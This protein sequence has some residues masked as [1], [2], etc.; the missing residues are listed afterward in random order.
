MFSAGNLSTC[1]QHVRSIQRRLDKAVADND[2]G[3]IRETFD[4][5]THRSQAVRVLA[6]W[7]ATQQH[8]IRHIAGIDNIAIPKDEPRDSQN[9]R[10]EK[11]VAAID[12]RKRPDP[13]RRVLIPEKRRIGVP[14][15]HDRIVQE[16]FRI[17]LEPIVEYHFNPRN[18]GC[19][20][21]R[22]A[23]DAV[24]QLLLD[25]RS[26][27]S[28]H[29][30]IRGG[31]RGCFGRIRV[32]PIR[33]TLEAWGTPAWAAET[34]Q[35][36]LETG[37]FRNGA[38][39]GNGT[40]GGLPPLLANVALTVLDA[41]CEHRGNGTH[42]STPIVR[43]VDDFVILCRSEPEAERVKDAVAEHLRDTL[44]L[45]R[46]E[47]KTR[48]VP[49]SKGFNFLG[50]TFREDARVYP[51]RA[52]VRSLLRA[53]KAVLETQKSAT[54]RHVIKRLTPKLMDWAMYYRYVDSAAAF[55]YVD[56]KLWEMLYRWAKR[57]HPNKS[58]GWVR[59][60]YFHRT[61]MRRAR[62]GDPADSAELP[63]L[64]KIPIQR[65]KKVNDT[66]RVYDR[67]PAAIEY[68]RKQEFRNTAGQIWGVKRRRLFEKQHGSCPYCR[69]VITGEDIQEQGT[70][71][72][73]VIPR[74]EGGSDNYSNLRLVHTACNAEMQE[75]RS[76]AAK[77]F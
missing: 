66:F 37:I 51:Q 58:N 76:G 2:K 65:F 31:I 39:C 29:Y 49:I 3:G 11:L 1:R 22:S 46:L 26:D 48:I 56:R 25:L 53:C 36:M 61:E 30:V 47:D 69:G 7:Q 8:A 4:L 77:S 71:I 50:F 74:A 64:P 27:D 34:L 59:R 73:H 40:A 42:V 44:G 18:Y 68:W 72:Q 21:K 6:T 14:T 13:I 62:F 24:S 45:T 52:R 19:R 15:L 67:D 55:A 54:Q 10:R 57:R 41:F 20:P 32:A 70:E 17:A 12:I 23:H 28:L 63:I 35:Q 16:I 75:K 5:L 38:I 60:R 43:Y 9:R 33:Q